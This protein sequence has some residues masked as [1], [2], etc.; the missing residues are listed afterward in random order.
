MQVGLLGTVVAQVDRE[1]AGVDACN[2]RLVVLEHVVV[3]AF[4]VQFLGNFV[5]RVH[6]DAVQEHVARFGLFMVC[7][8]GADFGGGEH[9]ELARVRGVSQDLLVTGH[10]GVEHG[11]ADGVGSS[12]KGVAPENGSVCQCQKRLLFAFRFPVESISIHNVLVV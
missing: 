12:A 3:Q 7:S 1:G 11:F 9:H 2:A 4:F 5:Q 6:D 10:A 8:V